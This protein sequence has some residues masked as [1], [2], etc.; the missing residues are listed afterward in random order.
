MIRSHLT[1]PLGRTTHR[2]GSVLT[3]AALALSL[4][5]PA[6]SQAQPG[7]GQHVFNFEPFAGVYFPD[8]VDRQPGESGFGLDDNRL[9]VGGRVSYVLPYNLFAEGGVAYS[10]LR[11]VRNGTLTNI[12]TFIYSAALGY[13]FRLLERAYFYLLAGGSVTQWLPN[14]VVAS[15]EGL[16]AMFGGGFRVYLT[17]ALSLRA[18][19]RDHMIPNTLD[20]LRARF[21][22]GMELD[23]DLTNNVEVTM[24]LSFSFP[25]RPAYGSRMERQVESRPAPARPAVRDGDA[26]GVA[27]DADRCP[28]TMPGVAVDVSGCPLDSD[29]DT[30]HDGIDRCPGTETGVR[31]DASGCAV[32]S[33]GDGVFDGADRCPNTPAEREVDAEGCSVVEAG[34]AEG[35]LTLSSVNFETGSAVLTPGARRVLNEVGRALLQRPQARVEIQGHTD[36]VGAADYNLRLSDARAQAVYRYLVGAYPALNPSRFIVRGLGESEP[37]ATNE[38]A[39]GRA[40]NRRVEFVIRE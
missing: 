19:A 15:V 23:G 11:F 9:M 10:P 16:G 20:E 22:P 4:L 17:P 3:V 21:N 26:D 39:A 13:N 6:R 28:G 18:E 25:A 31:V 7:Y 1:R 12:N 34:I 38:T 14:G 32:D 33:D 35:R 29:G 5:A 27:D 2:H 24:S 8:D 36:A 37:V 30:V 40:M